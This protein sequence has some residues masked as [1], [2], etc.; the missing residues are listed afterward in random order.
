MS[1]VETAIVRQIPHMLCRNACKASKMI[2]GFPRISKDPPVS[3]NA[4]RSV[5]LPQ[6]EAQPKDGRSYTGVNDASGHPHR[7]P[8]SPNSWAIPGMIKA[9]LSSLNVLV[10]LT[11]EIKF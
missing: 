3:S 8:P 1:F 4:S 11:P 7:L 2:P 10:H 5:R 6:G 9:N